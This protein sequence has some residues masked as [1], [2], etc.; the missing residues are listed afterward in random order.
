MCVSDMQARVADTP[1]LLLHP[2]VVKTA[3]PVQMLAF[4][5]DNHQVPQAVTSPM[6][7]Q[8]MCTS[9]S[10]ELARDLTQR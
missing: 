8:T 10:E 5:Q 7:I 3:Q 9:T 4:H 2:C 1:Y 6:N